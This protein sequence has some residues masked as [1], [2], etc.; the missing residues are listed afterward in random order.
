[1]KFNQAIQDAICNTIHD[2]VAPIAS[3]TKQRRD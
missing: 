1:M 2:C 3:L